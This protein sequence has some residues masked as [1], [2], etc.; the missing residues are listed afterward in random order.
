MKKVVITLLLLVLPILSSCSSKRDLPT[1]KALEDGSFFYRNTSLAF[2]VILP[3]EFE[4]YHT[5]KTSGVNYI[6]VEF[7]VP[8]SDERFGTQVPGYAKP[9][10]IRV[11]DEDEW[12]TINEASSIYKKLGE[13]NNKVYTILFWEKEPKD[14]Q[15]V[16][17]GEVEQAI[18]DNFE[19][20]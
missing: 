16:W 20:E 17:H 3:K 1:D 2:S 18:I 13:G 12:A 19:I 15:E 10:V 5:Q 9:I 8:T 4:N 11:F 14:W 6:D 7:F